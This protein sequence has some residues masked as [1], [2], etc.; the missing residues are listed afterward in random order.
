MSD[1]LNSVLEKFIKE[2]SE[3]FYSKNRSLRGMLQ[4]DVKKEVK[5][6]FCDR[7]F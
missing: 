4:K 5:L 6:Y 3:E 1:A 2:E 7:I